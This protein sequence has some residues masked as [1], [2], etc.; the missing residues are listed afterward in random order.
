MLVVVG[1]I[2]C[3]IGIFLVAPA[4]AIFTEEMLSQETMTIFFITLLGSPFIK[5]ILSLILFR[6]G[7]NLLYV[8][9]TRKWGVLVFIVFGLLTL[10]PFIVGD[11]VLATNILLSIGLLPF[12]PY[13]IAG[14]LFILAG[15]MGGR[16]KH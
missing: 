4:F 13:F 6:G 10:P 11:F 1:V 3:L 9:R 5:I 16:W 15:I 2:L 14:S 8:R 12:V 7:L